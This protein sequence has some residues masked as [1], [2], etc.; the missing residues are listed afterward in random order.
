MKKEIRQLMIKKRKEIDPI[1]KHD[2]DHQLV[3]LIQSDVDYQ[4]AHCI[5]IFYPMQSEINLLELLKDNKKF[6]FPKVEGNDIHFYLFEKQPFNKSSFGVLEPTKG[7]CV[8]AHIDYLITPALA[9]SKTNYRIG[10][11]KGFYDRFIAANNPKHIVGVIYDFQEVDEFET[12]EYDQKIDR[13][14][15]VKV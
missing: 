7:K 14:Y 15:K 1:T 3:H 9:I 12:H 10:Y 11:G 4:K 8:D 6:A 5:G 2:L 13:Y